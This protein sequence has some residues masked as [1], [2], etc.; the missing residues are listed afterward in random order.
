MNITEN[1]SGRA[2]GGLAIFLRE[3]IVSGQ[4]EGGE[5]L[6]S[7][8][9]LSKEHKLAP[10]T[11]QR[12]LKILEGEGLVRSEPRQGYRVKTLTP[13]KNT[14]G[15][16]AFMLAVR[17]GPKQWEMRRRLALL[18]LQREA[19][20]RGHSMLAIPV[21]GLPPEKVFEQIQTSRVSGV[22]M[23][24]V[25]A[26]M[27]QRG[28]RSALPVVLMDLGTEYLGLD[29]VAK[30]DFQGG[31]LAARYLIDRGH[32]EIA[33][34]GP[35]KNNVNGRIRF[36]GALAAALEAG[37]DIAA[38]NRIDFGDRPLVESARAFLSR[39]DRPR[40]VLALWRGTALAIAEACTDLGLQPGKD[41]DLVGWCSDEQYEHDYLGTFPHFL[42]QTATVSWSMA[43]TAKVV[44]SRLEE[45]KRNPG[46]PPIHLR[47]PMHIRSPKIQTSFEQRSPHSK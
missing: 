3:R 1:T 27:I 41:I 21:Q 25:N 36:G 14:D 16:I 2:S 17:E 8:R 30:D 34:F 32:K 5:F 12:A 26:P 24:E 37:L 20:L 40:A 23:D 35:L 44:L 15:P 7:V 45:R 19:A 33:W 29:G 42:P 6:P 13:A 28:Q 18:S 43:E 9:R 47:L 4:V 10:K 22:I 46:L 31:S 39:R 11:V 38:Q